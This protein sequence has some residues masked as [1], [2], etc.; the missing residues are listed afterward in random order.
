[1]AL[2]VAEVVFD[3]CDMSRIYSS[4]MT[5]NVPRKVLE[6]WLQG[7][8]FGRKEPYTAEEQERLKQDIRNLWDRIV[9]SKG[10][11]YTGVACITAGAPGSGKTTV[12]EAE[13]EQNSLFHDFKIAYVCPYSV[14]LKGMDLTYGADVGSS[15]AVEVRKAAYDKWRPGSN[16]AAHL[17]LAHL[18]R[19]KLSFYFGSTSTGAL[20]ANSFE[21]LKLQ[22]YH[23]HLLHVSAPDDVRWASIAKWDQEFVQTT[24]EDVIEKGKLLPQ[25]ISDTY[26]KYA[27]RIDFYWRPSRDEEA[28]LAAK[29]EKLTG[30]VLVVNREYYSN[31]KGVHDAGCRALEREDLLWE[32]TVGKIPHDFLM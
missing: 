32:N 14:C 15:T 13:I 21:F 28:L 31:I 29:F 19:D 26:L 18:I 16:A 11:S 30:V 3:P 2:S 20:M 27:S 1:M 8:G 6:E 23:I 25:R 7:V 17:I 10:K 5:Y 12:L 22:D 9:D 24:E 4:E